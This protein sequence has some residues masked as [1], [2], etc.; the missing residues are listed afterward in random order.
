LILNCG[1]G[2]FSEKDFYMTFSRVFLIFSS[3]LYI[4][5]SFYLDLLV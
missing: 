5:F 2:G 3:M 4:L 1:K